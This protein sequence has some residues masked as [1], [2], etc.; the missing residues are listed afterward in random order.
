MESD[1]GQSSTKLLTSMRLIL[2]FI[3]ASNDIVESLPGVD[4]HD[5]VSASRSGTFQI[6]PGNH[7][8]V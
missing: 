4:Y 6:V 2:I 5:L 7:L 3:R 8:T 1:A